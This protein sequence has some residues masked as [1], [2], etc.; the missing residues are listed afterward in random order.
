MSV[1]L[2]V[3]R[4]MQEVRNDQRHIHTYTLSDMTHEHGPANQVNALERS[5]E[6]QLLTP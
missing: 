2:N 4:K 1:S 3:K 5:T 6:T